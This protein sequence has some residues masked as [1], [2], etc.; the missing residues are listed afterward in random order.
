MNKVL[1]LDRDGTIIRDKN[2]LSDPSGIDWFPDSFEAL[3]ILQKLQFKI[4]ILTNQSGVARGYFPFEAIDLIHQELQKDLIANNLKGFDGF[5][6]CPH[7]PDDDCE[8]RKP[9]IKLPQSILHQL[10][11]PAE[12]SYVVGDKLIDAEC[13]YKLGG[14]GILVRGL[15]HEKFSSFTNLLEFAKFLDN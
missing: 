5:L 12:N 14:K 9:K 15:T 1:F 3:R 2:Y 13:G 8:C 7:S 10:H 11:I 4:Y 6:V